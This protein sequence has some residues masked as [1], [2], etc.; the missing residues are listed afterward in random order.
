[1]PHLTCDGP[2]ADVGQG[3]Y[4]LTHWPVT[5]EGVVVPCREATV[6]R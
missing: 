5:S 2:L 1:M 6:V 4:T 3:R